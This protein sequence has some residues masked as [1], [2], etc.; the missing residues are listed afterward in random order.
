MTIVLLY[1]AMGGFSAIFYGF[2]ESIVLVFSGIDFGFIARLFVRD[3]SIQGD[4]Q[5]TCLDHCVFQGQGFIVDVAFVGVD[6]DVVGHLGFD[7][8]AQ[9]LPRTITKDVGQHILRLT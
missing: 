9:H 2:L 7:R 6:G 3:I 1:T 5:V 8:L 4:I